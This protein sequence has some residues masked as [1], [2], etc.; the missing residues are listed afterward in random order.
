MIQSIAAKIPGVSRFVDDG[1]E[2]QSL[3]ELPDELVTRAADTLDQQD[4]EVNPD[5]L[6]K[7]ANYLLQVQ[8]EG[9][10][11]GKIGF[12][13]DREETEIADKSII[14]P[15]KLEETS[16]FTEMG[17][18]RRNDKYVRILTITD[19]PKYLPPGVLS[20][21]YTTH[22]NVRVTQH[23][24]PRDVQ[25]VLKKLQ[26]RLNR[27]WAHIARKREKGK[28]DT[29]EEEEE[30]DTVRRLIWDIITGKTKL[31][32]YSVYVEIIADDKRQLNNITKNLINELGSAHISVSSIDKLQVE[33]Q[34][35]MCPAARDTLGGSRHLMQ[36]TSL[37]TMF[38]FIGPEIAN[39]EGLIY[40]KDDGGKPIFFD[41]YDLSGFVEIITG[42]MGSGK[43]FAKMW[44]ILIRSYK[45]PHYPTW[46][47][48]PK[49]NFTALAQEIGGQVVYL[50]GDTKINPL[51]ISG[52]TV[53][54]VEDPYQ[55]KC[56]SV[57]GMYRTHIGREMNTQIE[58]TL[59]RKMHLAYL[60]YGI[61]PDERTHHKHAPIIQDHIDIARNIA[62]KNPPLDFMELEPGA[63]ENE[64]VVWEQIARIQ[65]RMSPADAERAEFLYNALEPFNHGGVNS[66][67]NGRTNVDLNSALVVFDMGMFA[68]TQQAPLMMHVVLDL[69]YQ[70][71][72]R[73]K[74]KDEV[75]VDEVHKL[76]GN[77]E[78]LEFINTF[79]RHHRHSNTRISLISQTADEFLVDKG[80]DNLRTEIYET[81]DIKR[82]FKHKQISE[83]M[84]EFH[85][86]TMPHQNFITS[87]AQGENA[88]H[89]QCLMELTGY[90]KIAVTIKPDDLDK[91]IVDED[92]S[93]WK[94]MWENGMIDRDFLLEQIN[95][96]KADNIPEEVCRDAN[97]SKG[98]RMAT[99]PSDD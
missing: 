7:Q 35:A 13:Q 72:S 50:G 60:K 30:R 82:I 83:E 29:Q 85:D 38:P 14:A 79:V 31:F 12:I 5:A 16:S 47:L 92:L 66:N 21:L 67:L 4:E 37:S 74:R 87:A 45:D 71:C 69:I 75:V 44:E 98:Q 23:I 46:V 84:A 15:D 70:R 32:D 64:E 17:Y 8:K 2:E 77:T 91:A 40:G 57:M 53:E 27:L 25:T 6:R 59:N 93:A 81:A 36:E 10:G 90:G 11:K 43:T 33:S 39:P 26:R 62:E 73:S 55:D 76:F 99:A 18:M 63:K 94:Y 49:S 78:A 68:D 34:G 86:L 96:N 97:I 19:Y 9:E 61:T 28:Q 88:G 56:R 52:E 3:E 95:K 1:V 24:E 48:D 22:A 89:S 65:E 42:K 20:D 58:A 51:D 54:E 80:D 41:P